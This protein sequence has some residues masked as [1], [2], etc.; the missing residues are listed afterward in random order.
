MPT[1][2]KLVLKLF[3]MEE[4]K[5]TNNTQLSPP[6][7]NLAWAIVVTLLCCWPFGIPAI[8]Y[9]AKVDSLWREGYHE[10]A[11]QAAADAKKWT[12]IAAIAGGVFWA[13]YILFMIVYVVL[14]GAG[15]ASMMD[16]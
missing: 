1:V 13:L 12:K 14:F 7:N 3:I 9:A 8:V 16:L 11:I 10:A 15:V 5:S 2:R 4:I 6:D